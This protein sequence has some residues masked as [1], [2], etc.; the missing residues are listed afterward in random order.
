MQCGIRRIFAIKNNFI[1]AMW[2]VSLRLQ[3]VFCKNHS[4]SAKKQE[5]LER[6]ERGDGEK[7]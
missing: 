2:L 3:K 7:K 5:Q 6:K 1:T 4:K